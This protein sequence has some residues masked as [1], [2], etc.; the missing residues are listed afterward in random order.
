MWTARAE[1]APKAHHV[2]I[3]VAE[4]HYVISINSTKNEPKTVP[5][6]TLGDYRGAHTWA[7]LFKG[8]RSS[9]PASPSSAAM[10]SSSQ[11]V[12]PP[13]RESPAAEAPTPAAGAQT[14]AKRP[15]SNLNS[16]TEENMTVD[17]E[18]D[19]PDGGELQQLHARQATLETKM[20]EILAMLTR[21]Q[22][23][24]PQV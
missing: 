9:L 3:Q 20:D 15:R 14:Q 16:D 17:D 1:H 5:T 8:K 21:M 6:K 10:S 7:D 18:A 13:K 24:S 11:P 2:P 23:P 22:I 19:A 4:E 12:R